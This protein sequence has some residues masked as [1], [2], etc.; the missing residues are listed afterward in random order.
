MNKNN[1]ESE[2]NAKLYEGL[3]IKNYKEL[4]E[5]YLG[6]KPTKG[7]CRKYHFKELE[8]YCDYH[9]EGQKIIIQKVFD[10]PI[11]KKERRGTHP[12]NKPKIKKYNSL[13]IDENK[14]NNI[15]VYYILLNND[16]YI[17]STI[18]GFRN[19]FQEHFYGHI[20]YMKHTYNLLH[21]GGTFNILYDMT[22]IED[23][24]LI[25]MVENEY[26]QYFKEYTDFNVINHVNGA[27]WKGKNY[28][29]KYKNIKIKIED[30][31]NAL[32]V[33]EEN[34]IEI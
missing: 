25:R 10:I 13:K 21:S 18:K 27:V 7:A 28:K 3:I 5:E 14:Y 24:E 9:K 22:N 2:L 32:K 33:L 31:N 11:E 23:V 15:G 6:V 4:C 30:Y 34:G 16:I 12:N 8:R 19:R 26:I 1:F 17:G 29:Q 20:E